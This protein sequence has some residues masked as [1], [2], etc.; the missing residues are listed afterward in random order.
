MDGLL[1]LTASRTSQFKL[2]IQAAVAS[3]LGLDKSA[4]SV[5]STNASRRRLMGVSEGSQTRNLHGGLAGVSA[6]Y[7]V[8]MAGTTATALAATMSGATST[9]SN[10]LST[11]GFIGTTINE[12]T[13]VLGSPS[14]TSP[15]GSKSSASSGT[16]SH[17][18][19]MI[20]ALAVVI[21][22]SVLL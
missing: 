9:I 12:A 14:P 2:A 7:V 18:A 16:R 1:L 20:S 15:T 21:V 4:V 5:Y 3:I 22:Q 19:I 11:Y 10:T 8:T 13:V 6:V 17:V